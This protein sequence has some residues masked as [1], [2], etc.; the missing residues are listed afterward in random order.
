MA[1]PRVKARQ[2]QTA[3]L[4]EGCLAATEIGVITEQ[5][6]YLIELMG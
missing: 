5:G 2:L 6:D 3:L 1:V 4:E